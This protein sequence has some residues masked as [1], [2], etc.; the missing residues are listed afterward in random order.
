MVALAVVLPAAVLVPVAVLVLAAGDVAE[1]ADVAD[2]FASSP[3][4]V[5]IACRSAEKDCMKLE[6][7]L[8]ATVPVLVMLSLVGLAADVV[9]AFELAEAC[10]TWFCHQLV[11][12]L[13]LPIDMAA[14]SKDV[15]AGGASG[16]PRW[17]DAV[18][19]DTQVQAGLAPVGSAEVGRKC[20]AVMAGLQ[21]RCRRVGP[22]ERAPCHVAHAVLHECR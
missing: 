11:D 2:V 20:P 4:C 22:Q 15:A 7:L 1:V 9:P 10:A 14:V 17:D 8:A 18:R 21:L 5:S 16:V 6:T 13:M 3:S 19:R 12:P